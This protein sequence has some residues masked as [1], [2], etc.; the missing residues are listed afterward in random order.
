[1]NRI[2]LFCLSARV[3]ASAAGAGDDAGWPAYEEALK[4]LIA[5]KQKGHKIEKVKEP[6]DDTNVVDLMD[7]LRRSLGQAPA[8]RRPAASESRKTKKEPSRRK[9]P[10]ASCPGR[11]PCSHRSPLDAPS[12]RALLPD[13]RG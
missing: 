9:A 10:A 6:E 3:A 1:M 5:D 13:W 11:P 12:P 8:S 4:A 7:A 2:L